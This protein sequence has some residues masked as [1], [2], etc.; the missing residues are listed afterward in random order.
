[1]RGVRSARWRLLAST[2]CTVNRQTPKKYE[3]WIATVSTQLPNGDPILRG[4]R[5]GPTLGCEAALKPETAVGQQ[6][7]VFLLGPLRSPTRGQPARHE[8]SS[9]TYFAFIGRYAEASR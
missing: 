5:A 7:V 8:S 1:M 9:V 3:R 2:F 6:S 4:E